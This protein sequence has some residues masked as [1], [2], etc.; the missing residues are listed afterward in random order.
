MA[1][2]SERDAAVI[3][4]GRRRRG[5]AGQV[6][7]HRAAMSHQLRARACATVFRVGVPMYESSSLRSVA[8]F[9]AKELAHS[10]DPRDT[11]S[12][13]ARWGPGQRAGK[14]TMAW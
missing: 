10:P 5:A 9:N 4:E 11:M 2:Q 14:Y 8:C 7:P 12:G 6:A 3:R 13:W 1:D